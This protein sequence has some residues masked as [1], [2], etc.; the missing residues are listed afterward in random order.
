MVKQ[1]MVKKQP[2]LEQQMVE[3]Q[4]IVE[5][6]HMVEGKMVEQQQIV[7]KHQTVEEQMVEQWKIVKK[8]QMVEKQQRMEKQQMMEEQMVEQLDTDDERSDTLAALQTLD[9]SIIQ[10]MIPWLHNNSRYN[11]LA[12][13]LNH[14]LYRPRKHISYIWFKSLMKKLALS[15][16]DSQRQPT[17]SY[18]GE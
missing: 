16:G 10:D 9:T 7:E 17:R 1:Q 13:P 3:Q 8:Q 18:K 12:A 6:Q 14:Y 11:T 5:K 2:K 4:Q 15:R